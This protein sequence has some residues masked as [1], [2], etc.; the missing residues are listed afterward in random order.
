ME[1]VRD[2]ASLQRY[3]GEAVSVSNDSPVLLDQF[4]DD[5]V[6]VDVD[7]VCD[8][9]RVV[10]AGIMEHI[11]EAG[12]HS[13]DS[14]CCL[15]PYSLPA[16]LQDEIRRQVELMALELGVI[17]LMNTQFAVQGSDIFVLEV[18]PRASRTVP[19]VSKACGRAYAKIGA[20]CM[21][22][23][24]LSEQGIL[25]EQVPTYFNVKES[26]FPFV[27]F[28]GVDPLLGPEMK[29]T[30]EVMGVGKTFGEAFG[31]ATLATNTLLPKSGTA[32]LSVRE[33]DREGLCDIAREL[34]E[35][36]FKL[37]AT[38][39]TCS[40]LNDSGIECEKVNKLRHGRPNILD[41][42]KN[43]DIDLIVNT[44]EGS[45]AV[46]DSYYIRKEALAGNV[47]YFTT[48]AAARAT[49][50][51][52]AEAGKEEVYSLQSLHQELA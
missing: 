8:G 4:L 12:V 35:I 40:A 21:A 42:M 36:G 31:K 19:F 33:R 11:E 3:M 20:L 5:A 13:G 38:P 15:P 28:P 43:R 29:S 46:S 49:C 25:K 34:L 45:K 1:I 24:T 51:A 44:T 30:G 22:G 52:L 7:A 27:K 50:K 32:F 41:Q 17:G 23:T 2:E 6:E 37:V 26:V 47:A 48:L 18:N 14:A 16:E 39:G 10:I 9:E